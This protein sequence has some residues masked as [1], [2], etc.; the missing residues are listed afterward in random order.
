V[1]TTAAAVGTG[2]FS[3]IRRLSMV[4]ERNARLN[5]PDFALA[6]SALQVRSVHL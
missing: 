5:G 3:I 4:P 6:W 2:Q 1:T